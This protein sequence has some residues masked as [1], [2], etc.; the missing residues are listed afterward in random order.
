MKRF[1]FTT[2]A[3]SAL[4]AAPVMAEVK[5]AGSLTFDE[6]QAEYPALTQKTWE[7]VDNNKDGVADMAEI[8][9][10]EQSDILVSSAHSSTTSTITID[11]ASSEVEQAG[12]LTFSELKEEYPSL[13]QKVWEQVDNNKDGVADMEEIDQA[14]LSDVLEPNMDAEG[15]ASYNNG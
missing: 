6:L 12:S 15:N 8:D 4:M 7:E 13:T 5:Q 1:A 2:V 9:E 14:E 3:L 11:P 10:A